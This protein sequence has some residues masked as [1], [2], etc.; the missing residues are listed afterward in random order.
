MSGGR[1][2]SPGE[3]W[4]REGRITSVGPPGEK[5]T[6]EPEPYPTLAFPQHWLVPGFI[7]LHLHG[8]VG[9]DLMQAS[10]EGLGQ[11]ALFLASQGTTGFL[12]T[13][14]SASLEEV[15][16]VCR[17]VHQ[18]R[19][20][21]SPGA[22]ILGLHLEGPY[23]SPEYAGAHPPPRLRVPKATE[24]RELLARG[25]GL[26]KM[27]TLAPELNGADD[28]IEILQSHG[29]VASAGHSGAGYLQARRARQ[30]GISHVT[31][32]FN[33]MKPWH[34]REPGLAGLALTEPGI[35]FELIADGHHLHPAVVDMCLRAAGDRAVL[36]SD[37][38][39]AMGLPGGRYLWA[40]REILVDGEVARFSDGRLAG[41]LLGLNTA[42]R[43][44]SRW[45]GAPL[46][47]VIP[48]VTRNPARVLG[49]EAERGD[50]LPGRWADLVVLDDDGTVCLTMVEGEIVYVRPGFLRLGR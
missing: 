39:P 10:V 43:N 12:A 42:L 45:L 22:R 21:A 29:V 40:G 46:E 6:K 41:G 38:L 36:V 27:V 49:M 14:L 30:A 50:L 1:T 11:V 33:A 8:A 48:L 32:L 37:A 31:H 44:V 4:V 25:T 15:T 17:T 18:T 9:A 19:E 35:S 2:L 23:L 26:I 28:V 5:E 3:V 16:A 24:V 20:M 47:E 7:D 13:T 34:H